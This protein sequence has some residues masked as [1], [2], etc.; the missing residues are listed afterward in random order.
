[1]P[2]GSHIVKARKSAM[3]IRVRGAVQGVGFR[4]FVWGLAEE[5]DLVGWVLNDEDGVLIHAE[6]ARLGAFLSRV[7][8]EAPSLSRVDDV[9]SSVVESENPP[10]FEIRK[11]ER[12]AN[13]RTMITPDVATCNDCLD[14]IFDP[15]NRRY[16]YPFTNCT[17]CGPRYTITR[18]LPYDR[19]ET[20]MASFVMCPSCKREYDH[21]ADRRFHAQP[22]A[23]PD[24][25]PRLSADPAEI[26]RRLLAGEIVAL[27]GLGGF[28]L[29]VDA[30]NEGAVAR[31]RERKRRD[32]KPF[33]VMV[34]SEESA[35]GLADLTDSDLDLLRSRERP[36]VVAA[37]REES[38]LASG[39]CRGLG[40]LGLF[41]PYT[42]LHY[43]LFHEAAG[44][45]D[46]RTWLNERQEMAL[47]MT[48]ANPGGE[49][50]VTG[51]DEAR[52]R[53]AAI[54]DL[55]VDHDRDVVTR[56]DDSVM[57][58]ID[59]APAYLRRAR[60]ACPAPIKLSRP[61]RPVLGL[62]GHLKTTVCAIRGDEAYLSQ[63]IG[64]LDNAETYRFY[65]E[66]AAH[67]VDILEVEPELVACDLHP[68][69]LS[70]RFAEEYGAPVLKIQH[71]HAHI[72]AAA[73]EH[74]I[75]GPVAGLALD[76]FGLGVDNESWGGE[77][78]MMDGPAMRRLGSLSP[79][80][81]PGGDRA[82]REPWRM[83]ASALSALGR[84]SE[85]AARFQ[86]QNGA[87][88]VA[89]MLVSGINAPLTSSAG[90][91]FDAACGILGVASIASFEGEAAMRL[92]AMANAPAVLPRGWRIRG[93]RLDF[94]PL[95]AA[96]CETDAETGANLFHGTLAE[97]LADF[98]A[99]RLGSEG[100]SIRRITAS[101]GCL[102]N[103]VLTR[104]LRAALLSR[105]IEL[106]T[107]RAAPANDGGLSFGQ[108]WIA[109]LTI[110]NQEGGGLC[111]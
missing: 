49:P 80:R 71:H 98:V 97:G 36:I 29:A 101:G 38:G 55:I 41:L 81:Q 76:G 50:L 2:D 111:A 94:S 8:G 87:E 59:G 92:E 60:G 21:P 20:S 34:A 27:K 83:G 42:P 64:D 26:V 53:L 65:K 91:L 104:L 72:A 105:G 78:L 32:G 110:E 52:E 75:D 22:N 35:G 39:V 109:A 96:L 84:G 4:P 15:R 10:G 77:L 7:Q 62:G 12:G 79:L 89:E 58:V 25:G 17:N 23:C 46:G 90:R 24:C 31:L 45:P 37:L 28:H 102:Q 106:F 14:D 5:L 54:A 1:M 66:T 3:R 69:F 57:R 47:V 16:G 9:E 33:A 108:A 13:A 100:M 19:S 107:P 6:G 56:C 88:F 82:A 40:S 95:L 63:H 85:I 11:S 44:R 67:L 99:E 61:M 43:L 18:Q 48:S 73:A 70:T 74:H 51:N 103:A 93:D 68:D 30:R 86:K